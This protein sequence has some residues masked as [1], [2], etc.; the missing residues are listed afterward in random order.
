MKIATRMLTARQEGEW[1][2][3]VRVK[4]SVL[5]RVI[6]DVGLTACY[7]RLARVRSQ[8]AGVGRVRPDLAVVRGDDAGDGDVD[9]Q[10][11]HQVWKMHRDD[12]KGGRIG[13]GRT[14]VNIILL[15]GPSGTFGALVSFSLLL[16][17]AEPGGVTDNKA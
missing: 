6:L 7:G 16:L 2:V 8:E 13:G 14:E 1:E 11:G 10:V 12:G 4:R 5:V 3:S 17:A 15:G 9:V